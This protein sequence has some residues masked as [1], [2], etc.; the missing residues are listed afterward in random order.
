MSTD[1]S[2]SML[3]KS[4]AKESREAYRNIDQGDARAVIRVRIDRVHESVLAPISHHQA[5]AHDCERKNE[6]ENGRAGI[7]VVVEQVDGRVVAEFPERGPASIF[8]LAF[9]PEVEG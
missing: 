7:D 5:T 6:H 2:E 4:I 9:P 8:E 1:C 3:A